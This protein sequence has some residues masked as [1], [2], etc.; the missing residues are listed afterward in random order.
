MTT[1]VTALAA[2]ATA[3]V[4]GTATEA[5]KDAYELLKALIRRRFAGRDEARRE[6]EADEVEPGTWRAR[7][8]PDLSD[9]GAAGDEQILVAARELLTATGTATSAGMTISVDT[10]HGAIGEFTGPVS[11]DQRTHLPPTAPAAD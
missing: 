5:V 9:S 7:I 10:N 6:L 4:S 1:I 2:G 8:G 11:F 3:G